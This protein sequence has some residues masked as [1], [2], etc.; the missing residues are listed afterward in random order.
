MDI[1]ITSDSYAYGIHCHQEGASCGGGTDAFLEGLRPYDRVAY[2]LCST[3]KY[4]SGLRN[5]SAI[6]SALDPFAE[7]LLITVGSAEVRMGSRDA[8]LIVDAICAFL[9]NHSETLDDIISPLNEG[10]LLI[11]EGERDPNQIIALF[12]RK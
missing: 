11:Q 12:S 10:L 1:N 7:S 5:T 4:L 9:E 6:L 2:T 8:L 3:R